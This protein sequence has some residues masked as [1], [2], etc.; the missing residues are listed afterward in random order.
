MRYLIAFLLLPIMLFAQS[1]EPWQDPQVTQIN[2]LPARATSVSF[3]SLDKA[4]QVEPH[5]SGRSISLNG[6][7]KFSWAPV[8][9]KESMDF[10]EKS[11]GSLKW[12]TIPVPG[13]WEMYGYGMPM[14]KNI[15]YPFDPVTPPIP[16]VDDN[17]VGMYMRTFDIPDAWAD[18]QIS[19]QFGGVSSA[20]YVWLNGEMVGYSEDSRLPA[21]FDITPF[22]QKG[23]NTLAVKVYRWS[24]GSYLEDQDHWRL[25]GLHRE[26]TLSA[27]PKI[28]IYDFA[29]RTP[30]DQHHED[31]TLQIRPKVKVYEDQSLKGWTIKA[32]LYDSNQE[33]VLA[34][35][36]STSVNALVNKKMPPTGNVPFPVMETT[37]TN[38][39]KW[40]AE[41]PNLY[42]LVLKLIDDND[43]V[44]E[45]R[46]TKVGFRSVAFD[47]GELL[48]NGK[49]VLLYGVNRHDHHKDFGKA[50]TRESMRRDVELM[51]LFN[52]NAVRTSHYPNDPYFYRLCDEY[53]LY[54]IDEANIETHGLGSQLSNDPQWV[55]AHVE[56]GLRMVERDKNHPSIIFWSLGNESGMGPN[57]AAMSSYMKEL[58]HNRPIKY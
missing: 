24:D 5:A 25:S 34:E 36:L 42:T 10:H 6:N 55:T 50:V 58:D 45:F 51:K 40:S 17:P 3:S 11:Y 47:D 1:P 16:P 26:V 46:S 33:P 53:G 13:N 38:P 57:H 28:Q 20:F 23:T 15:N 31:A 32:Q 12:A 8:A 2:R 30:L 43:N 48:V 22:L 44:Q 21:E 19:L 9:G 49:S 56:R 27:S 14:Y 4:M 7:W 18:M 37:V 35:V 39:Q 52:V 54:V 29:V 41:H